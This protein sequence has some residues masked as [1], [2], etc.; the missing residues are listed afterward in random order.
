MRKNKKTTFAK[1][2]TAKRFAKNNK[3]KKRH[4]SPP[5][6]ESFKKGYDDTVR[7]EGKFSGTERGFGF[8]TADESFNLSTDIFI[9]ARFCGGAFTGDRVAILVRKRELKNTGDKFH[10]EGEVIEILERGCKGFCGTLILDTRL[11]G[12]SF[13]P[14]RVVPDDPKLG[15]EAEIDDIKDIDIGNKVEVKLLDYGK[16]PRPPKGEIVRDLGKTFS[17]G[18][19]YE[20]V[21]YEHGIR[22]EFPL[23]AVR[24]A[25]EAAKEP[26]SESGRL[27]LRDKIIFTI[28]G[29]DAKDLDD[30]ISLDVTKSGYV[31][32]V[33]IADVSHYVRYGTPTDKE[34]FA[35]GTSVYFTDKV[36]PMLPKCLSNGA[37]SLNADTDKYALSA[38]IEMSKQGE[39]IGCEV[40]NTII[41]S[42]V[43]GVYSE[44]NDLFLNK[45]K[46]K[47]YRKYKAVYKTLTA[48]YPLYEILAN[49]AKSRGVLELESAEA[50]FVLDEDGRPVDIVKRE[51]GDAEKM[52]EQ[53]MLTANEAV[54]R[55]MC[56]R[57]LPS[58]FRVH[59]A[60]SEE[61]L[62]A[63]KSYVH[64]AG[65]ST[66]SL[67]AKK[68]TTAAFEPIIKEAAEKGMENVISRLTLR[69]QMKAK[70]SETRDDH[71]G[72]GLSYYCHFTSP[73]RRY[74]DLTVHRILKYAMLNG[75]EAAIKRY[76]KF[77][78]ESAAASSD[79]E[80]KA[81]TA[82]R[83]IEDLYKVIFMEKEVGKEFDAVISSVTSFG[84]FCELENT[85]E[86]FIPIEVLGNGFK[87]R[88]ET[89]TLGRG[90][91]Q[92]KLG[93]PLR[94]KITDANVLRRRIYMEPVKA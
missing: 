14:Y 36:V 37:C 77:A 91:E 4:S 43:R 62:E 44:V 63:Y 35:R 24:C 46:S 61:K 69:A 89:L 71:F 83:D 59:E 57:S 34:A 56:A 51:R 30:A 88:E 42:K 72:L 50:R 48:M 7:I 12:R 11:L 8:V 19:N 84:L 58:V 23:E 94:I 53:F 22:T 47:F 86:G 67:R 21:L 32:G 76:T 26:I 92:Y 16:G 75:E 9:P 18:A 28:D 38:I 82:E 68:L 3:N 1:S 6:Y 74:P 41:R 66:V 25:E 93:Q 79:N 81:M 33:H 17:L 73:I 87:F 55:Y 10:A 52:I 60:P 90:D 54:A 49:R 31:L 39:I 65:L 85:C 40:K 78:A 13:S 29:A 15:L 64:N 2:K 20:S 80:L 70:Y 27:D 45:S 5:S